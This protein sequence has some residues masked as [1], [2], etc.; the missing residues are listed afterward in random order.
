MFSICAK[1]ERC[2]ADGT[3]PEP[4]SLQGYLLNKQYPPRM[5]L[6]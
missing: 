3:V 2:V 1:A 5:T 4:P 6:Q